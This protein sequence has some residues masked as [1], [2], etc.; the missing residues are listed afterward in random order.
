MNNGYL[1]VAEAEGTRTRTYGFAA[2][3]PSEI[4]LDSRAAS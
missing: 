3:R 4:L 2:F 1:P